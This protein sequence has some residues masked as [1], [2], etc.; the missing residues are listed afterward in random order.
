MNDASP[1][2]QGLRRR[3]RDLLTET[4]SLLVPEDDGRGGQA[5]AVEHDSLRC[6]A[7]ASSSGPT[8][9]NRQQVDRSTWIFHFALDAPVRREHVI[10]YDGR[11]FQVTGMLGETDHGVLLRVETTNITDER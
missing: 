6:R 1:M 3:A 7:F 2:Q 10:E 5:L 11:R 8:R 4:C 9:E